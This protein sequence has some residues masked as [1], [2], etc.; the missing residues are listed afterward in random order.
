LL[1]WEVADG[2]LLY[3]MIRLKDQPGIKKFATLPEL[4]HDVGTETFTIE[5]QFHGV[6]TIN[7]YMDCDSPEDIAQKVYSITDIPVPFIALYVRRGY[8]YERLSPFTELKDDDHIRVVLRDPHEIIHP[9]SIQYGHNNYKPCVQQ[10]DNGIMKFY[11]ILKFLCST[12]PYNGS[13]NYEKLMSYLMTTTNFPPLLYALQVLKEHSFLSIAGW[14]ALIEGCYFLFKAILTSLQAKFENS[15]VFEYADYIWS[16]F[17]SQSHSIGDASNVQS[18]LYSLVCPLS[19]VKICN[20]VIIEGHNDIGSFDKDNI[21]SKIKKNE[22]FEFGINGHV[23][24]EC[25]KNNDSIRK[26]LMCNPWDTDRK[27]CVWQNPPKITSNMTLKKFEVTVAFS[28]FAML[29]SLHELCIANP[30]GLFSGAECLSYNDK[31]Q[32][33][34]FMGSAKG[35][36]EHRRIYN[37]LSSNDDYL[38][39]ISKSNLET[40]GR[41]TSVGMISLNIKSLLRNS[42]ELKNHDSIKSSAIVQPQNSIN[43]DIE[44][45]IVVLLDIGG[46]MCSQVFPDMGKL[47]RIDAAKQLFIAFTTRT[48]AYK[49]HNAIGLTLFESRVEVK[50]RIDKNVEKFEDILTKD[51]NIKADGGTHLTDAVIESVNQLKPFNCRKR[52]VCLTDGDNGSRTPYSS[53]LSSAI[54]NNV[55]VDTIL[56]TWPYDNTEQKALSHATGGVCVLPKSMEE[57][58]RYFEIDGMLSMKEREMKAIPQEDMDYFRDTSKYPYETHDSF[59]STYI[60][61]F[62]KVKTCSSQSYLKKHKERINDTSRQ[63]RIIK[64]L[65]QF[66]NEPHENISVYPSEQDLNKWKVL[67]CDDDCVIDPDGKHVT[68]YKG[69]NFVLSVEFPEK[70][71]YIP[72][73]IRFI[74]IIHHCNV[75]SS[76]GR[77]CHAILGDSYTPSTSMR[78]ILCCI[79]GL[80]MCPDMDTPLDGALADEYGYQRNRES[81]LNKQLDADAYFDAAEDYFISARDNVELY[82][83][84]PKDVLV[85]ELSGVTGMAVNFTSQLKFFGVK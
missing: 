29:K 79:Y 22:N 77:I 46:S 25:I 4:D 44:E 30:Q 18:E 69:G 52:I 7:A 61:T 66:I 13:Y 37:P 41:S 72:P 26:L 78:D 24:L 68:Q 48:Q 45:A 9:R 20:P 63:R 76:S 12:Q 11:S 15:K 43:W 10:S 16:H 27:V 6:F 32:L 17:I 85:K 67:I 53:A 74:T 39:L 56:L 47:T 5:T 80:L 2:D 28:W 40:F 75:S 83:N 1:T 3:A 57:A 33:V 70:Y 81:D 60:E 14:T 62:N 65:T 35:T 58:L 73:E 51:K 38:E 54:S 31:G 55:V 36:D 64:E 84:Q 34:Y 82:A 49:L 71:P 23:P 42:D 59:K 8:T 50:L 21:L 19:G